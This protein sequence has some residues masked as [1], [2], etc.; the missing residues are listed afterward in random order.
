MKITSEKYEEISVSHGSEILTFGRREGGSP[1]RRKVLFL[2][3]PS[4]FIFTKKPRRHIPPG[5]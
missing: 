3:I 4:L 1:I 2:K 5:T